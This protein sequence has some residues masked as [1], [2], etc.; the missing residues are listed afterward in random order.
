[1]KHTLILSA[2]VLAGTLAGTEAATVSFTFTDNSNLL[3]SSDQVGA[4]AYRDDNWNNLITDWSGNNSGQDIVDGDGNVVGDLHSSAGLQVTYDANTNY[5][6]DGANGTADEKL[7]KRYLDDG[8]GTGQP[9]ITLSNIANA[10]QGYTLIVYLASDSANSG[11][12]VQLGNYWVQ[13]QLADAGA[14]IL[15]NGGSK[16]SPLLLGDSFTGSYVEASE[17]TAGNYLVFTGL[18]AD[19]VTIR[20]ERLSTPTRRASIAGFQI[21]AIPE[22]SSTAL[23]GLAGLGFILRRRR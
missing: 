21:V 7:F 9:Y 15:S 5:F 10:A 6:T 17:S 23:I 14:T 12:D 3:G 13:D 18:T 11:A 8:G 1:M 20:S 19:S 22:P 16:I 4:A 2:L